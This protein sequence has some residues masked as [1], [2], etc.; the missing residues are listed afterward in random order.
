MAPFKSG[1]PNSKLLGFLFY[2][3]QKI[4]PG[5]FCGVLLWAA[6]D[7]LVGCRLGSPGLCH[8]HNLY[9]CYLDINTALQVQ[10]F[11]YS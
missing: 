2:E 11:T 6:R 3:F 8:T 5:V 9:S 7:C 1:D 4:M 10:N